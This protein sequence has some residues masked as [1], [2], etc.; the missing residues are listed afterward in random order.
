MIGRCACAVWII[1]PN[2]EVQYRY[3]S[4]QQIQAENNS[5][6]EMSPATAVTSY[7][8]EFM[9]AA[10]EESVKA[11]LHG[12]IPFGAV[13][14]DSSAT[15]LARGHNLCSAAGKH[16][17]G[18]GHRGDVTRHAK[19]EVVRKACLEID[20]EIRATCTLY[21]STEPCVMWCPC[22]LLVTH[23]SSGLQMFVRRT[24]Q[25]HRSGWL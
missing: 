16:R 15:T 6:I 20:A 19:V 21:G 10:I 12:H 4:S 24:D 11:V 17:G 5:I 3:D 22:H 8:E 7:H 2:R 25:C 9:R 23:R 18:G 13:I 1:L 14:S